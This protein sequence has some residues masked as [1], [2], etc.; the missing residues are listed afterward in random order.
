MPSMLVVLLSSS[1]HVAVELNSIF[2][3]AKHRESGFE[4][5]DLIMHGKMSFI[6]N[7][8]YMYDS[9]SNFTQMLFC[10]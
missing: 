2:A 4:K 1:A 9:S 10:K 6:F 3:S 7:T 5:V 8:Q